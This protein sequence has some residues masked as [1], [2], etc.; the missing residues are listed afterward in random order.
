M[1]KY[2]PYLPYILA[3]FLGFA[4]YQLYRYLTTSTL[5]GQVEFRRDGIDTV[6]VYTTLNSVE[7]RVSTY[8][9]MDCERVMQLLETGEKKIEG[10][11]WQ[12]E[13]RSEKPMSFVI[14]YRP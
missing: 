9:P 4:G 11:T 8:E 1:K 6:D 12:P 13:C 5:V 7:V 3:F 14:E 10:A 2:S